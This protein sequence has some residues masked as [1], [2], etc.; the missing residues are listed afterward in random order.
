MIRLVK[1]KYDECLT[2]KIKIMGELNEYQ[3]NERREHP[4][5]KVTV[6]ISYS[7][8]L[9]GTGVGIMRDISEKG[10]CFLTD[11]FLT[12]GLILKS[13]FNLPQEGE[14]LHIEAIAK[15]MW[16]KLT[17]EGYLVGVKVLT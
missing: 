11:R 10:F 8:L 17:E 4:R 12:P 6:G 9:P 5:K 16:C 3:G 2:A 14:P 15:V 7:I 13:D 1:Y